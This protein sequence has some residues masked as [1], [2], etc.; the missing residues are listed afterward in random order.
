MNV[1]VI[2]ASPREDGNSHLLAEA[3]CA[4]AESAGHEVEHVFLDEYVD[5]MLTNC[6]RCRMANG[7]C[8]LDDRY[9]SLLLEKMLPAD[10]II[11]AMPLYFYGMPARLKSVF[12]RLFCYTSNSAPQQQQVVGGITDKT[13]GV[14]ISCEESYIG[15]TA[16]VIAQFQELTRYLDQRLAGVVVGNANS[17]GEIAC[18]PTD[19]LSRARDLGSRLF[20]IRVTDYRLTTVRSNKVWDPVGC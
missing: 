17:R 6:R 11:Y 1:L 19:P 13:V 18:D 10:G 16:G 3:A 7:L 15:A 14:L 12:D 8:S 2:S 9:E 20:D 4:G 5:R